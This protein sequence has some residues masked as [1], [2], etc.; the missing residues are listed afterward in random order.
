M[1]LGVVARERDQ[2]PGAAFA[3]GAVLLQG[4]CQGGRLFRAL[5]ILEVPVQDVGQFSGIFDGLAGTLQ[6]DVS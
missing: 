6:V 3:E 5:S 2:V 1:H 4:I